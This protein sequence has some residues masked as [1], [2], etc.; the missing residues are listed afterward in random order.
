MVV[1]VTT[2]HTNTMMQVMNVQK[3]ELLNSN[4]VP[5][6]FLPSVLTSCELSPTTPSLAG[7]PIVDVL[8]GGV[9]VTS[10]ST[11]SVLA[12]GGS[13]NIGLVPRSEMSMCV[14]TWRAELGDDMDSELLIDGILHGF[15]LVDVDAVPAPSDCGNYKSCLTSNNKPLVEAQI[16]H[17]IDKGR[18]IVADNIPTCVSSLGAIPKGDSKI[19]LIHDLSR[20]FGGINQH[21]SDKSISYPTIDDAL[22]FVT[23][24]SYL[25]KIDLREAYR[26]VPLH[27]SCFDL[28]GLKWR[29]DGSDK[30][31]FLFD[32]RL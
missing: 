4:R 6:A 18:Y 16:L 21:C 13:P 17:E 1:V 3:L 23:S 9:A 7:S 8:N 27:A 12:S 14:D 30:D 29:F 24:S 5:N 31:T 32:S 22:K 2:L 25:A 20:P 15:R 10:C 11:G 19:R 28:T 26:S